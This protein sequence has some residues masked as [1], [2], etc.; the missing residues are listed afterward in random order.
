MADHLELPRRL[1]I[2][3]LGAASVLSDVVFTADATPQSSPYVE[4]GSDRIRIGN[5]RLEL[6]FR[7]DN[8]GIAQL[9]AKQLGF[10]L[11]SDTPFPALTWGLRFYTRDYDSLAT[12]SYM[13]GAPEIGATESADEAEL[14]LRWSNPPLKAHP[15]GRLDES[16]SGQIEVTVTVE[17][18]DPA[19]YWR[20]DVTNEDDLAVQET[21]CPQVTNVTPLADDGSDAF[22]IPS[23]LGRKFPDPTSFTAGL[24]HRYPS[25]YG[26]MQFIAYLA[27][28]AGIYAAAEDTDG[29]EKQ[30]EL[31]SRQRDVLGY[32]A[33]HL[34]PYRPGEDVTLPYDM[35]LGIHS[36]DW[37]DACDRY[38]SWVET[39]GWLADTEPMVPEQLRERGVS[40]HARSYTRDAAGSDQ[41]PI[42]FDTMEAMVSNLQ[43]R[44]DVPMGFRWWGWETNGRPAGGD[45]FP[46]KEGREAFTEVIESL[47][48]QDVD[49]IGFLNPTLALESSDYWQQLDRTSGLPR[50]TR[51]GEPLTMTDENTGL[52]FYRTEPTTPRW[53][54]HYES[55]L[56]KLVASGTTE[57]DLDGFPWGW[58]S[59]C[60]NE[61]HDHPVGRGG[62][63]SSTRMRSYLQSLHSSF[64][65][66]GG[67]VLGGEGIAD[68][69]LP[70]L[71]SHVIR[72]G[73]V[74]F[75]DPAVRKGLA[76][77]VPMFPY[78]FGAYAET[79]SQKGHIGTFADQREVQRLIAG[80]AIDWGSIPLFMGHY[81]PGPGEYDPVL[82][83][84]YARIGA[85][86]SG[87]GNRFLARG[88]MLS[89]PEIDRRTVTISQRGVET[90]THELRGRG[91][92]AANGDLGIVLT[93]VS[94][95]ETNR[96]FPLDLDAQSFELPSDP[97]GYVVRNGQYR[98]VDG[99]TPRIDIAPGDVVLLAAIQDSP[100]AEEALSKLEQAQATSNVPDELLTEAKRA[101]DERAYEMAVE[102]ATAAM[103]R[104]PSATQSPD[105]TSTSG[106]RT[107]DRQQSGTPTPVPTTAEQETPADAPGFGIGTALGGLAGSGL[108][109]KWLLDDETD[110][111]E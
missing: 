18:D 105:S 31:V 35:T 64:D 87:Y 74:E 62:N 39:S 10:S 17:R 19:S 43:D 13:A 26:T 25:G 96:S 46:P 63:W 109:L 104:T 51:G 70:Y 9:R 85:A 50:T 53:R 29:Y 24:T 67:L 15:D 98:A 4:E 54:I 22:Y 88:E 84:Y 86:R 99:L 11:R 76:E 23:R 28:E 90:T 93:N 65:I 38:R 45:W 83:E 102:K 73:M 108:L 111:T 12:A 100:A 20:I 41:S 59:R 68:F 55:A 78:T 107:S 2:E 92:R 5:D 72:D 61:A 32:R 71:N 95:L 30:F 47:S 77:V 58:P 106:S 34:V 94:N 69:Y 21:I 27:D 97:L 80:R 8:G 89:P 56:E 14:S 16:F 37:R 82:L 33:R 44:L 49:T 57:L 75:D 91:W 3:A 36:G 66:D 60:W 103:A 6:S 42:S 81:D 40:Y 48:E 110:D 52:T 7:R 1:F 101:F 79:R